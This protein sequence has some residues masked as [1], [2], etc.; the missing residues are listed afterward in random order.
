MGWPQEREG[1]SESEE[2]SETKTK[3]KYLHD[4]LARDLHV[5]S[6]P[7][8]NLPNLLTYKYKPTWIE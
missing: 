2:Q 5:L 3:L 6:S 4:D 8:R 7:K 1:R